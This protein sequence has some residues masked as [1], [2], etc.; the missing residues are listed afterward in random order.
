MGVDGVDVVVDEGGPVVLN[1]LVEVGDKLVAVVGGDE[2]ARVTALGE[3]DVK[4]VGEGF[5]VVGELADGG[6]GVKPEEFALLVVVLAAFPVR[7]GGVAAAE[8]AGGD[9]GVFGRRA[10]RGR[11]CNRDWRRRRRACR[12]TAPAT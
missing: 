9:G 11:V 6:V 7:P 2:R 4:E 5:F 10:S 3:E 12:G 1:D 8:D